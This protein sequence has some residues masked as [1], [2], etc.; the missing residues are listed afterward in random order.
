MT[1]PRLACSSVLAAISVGL[2]VPALAQDPPRRKSGLWEVKGETMPP[3]STCVDQASDD[4]LRSAAGNMQQSNCKQTSMKREGNRI[5]SESVCKMGNTTATTR[6]V[7][8]GDFETA[9]TVESTS[10]YEPPLAG[11][12]EGRVKMDARWVGPCKP[13]MKPG[14]MVM[15]NGQVISGEMMRKMHEAMKK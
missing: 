8:S 15:P 11:R 3:M 1:L 6:T 10:K 13:G 12:S 7:A 5:V 2:T 14:D 9:Y 4:A